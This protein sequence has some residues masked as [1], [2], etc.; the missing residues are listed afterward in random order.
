MRIGELSARTGVSARS[1]RYYEQQ[2]LLISER[3]ANTYR[4]YE[5][6]A[7]QVV[8]TIQDLLA[9]GLATAV[10]REILPCT[11]GDLGCSDAC[12]DLIAR[13][14]EIREALER[15]A[16][17]VAAQKDRLAHYLANVQRPMAVTAPVGSR[18]S[19]PWS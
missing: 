4:D 3:S 6:D 16:E 17:R 15:Q 10:I 2:G 8:E 13:V 12:P 14:V 18:A 5:P 7:V 9:A 1:L 19:R 11:G